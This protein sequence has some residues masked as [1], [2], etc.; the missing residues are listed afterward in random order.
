MGLLQM[1]FKVCA[2][3]Q[4]ELRCFIVVEYDM[5]HN[6]LHNLRATQSLDSEEGE[7]N[8]EIESQ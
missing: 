6:D 5:I 7:V 8:N 3:H 1:F 4:D 2:Q